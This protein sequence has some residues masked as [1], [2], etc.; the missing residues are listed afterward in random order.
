VDNFK[1]VEAVTDEQKDQG[2][3]HNHYAF[4]PSPNLETLEKRKK[5]RKFSIENYE[6]HVLVDN[7]PVST[8]IIVPMKQ[9]IRGK[10]FPMGGVAGV[11]TYPEARRKGYVKHLIKHLMEYMYDNNFVVSTLYPFRESFYGKFGWI[12]FN[13]VKVAI[14]SPANLHPLLKMNFE[15]SVS[16]SMLKEQLHHY[17][18]IIK[19]VVETQHGFCSFSDLNMDR[20]GESELWATVAKDKNDKAIGFM[21]YKISGFEGTFDVSKFLYTTS[22]GKYLL[23][24]FLARH[25]DQ[26]KSINM[27]LYAHENIENWIFDLRPEI[28]S[29]EWVPTAMGRIINLSLLSGIYVRPGKLFVNVVDEQLPKNN[30][31]WEF[32]E[33]NGMLK[34]Q[35]VGEAK[36][37]ISIQALS[38]IVYGTYTIE[39]IQ[40]QSEVE[41]HD[42]QIQTL[43]D[44]FSTQKVSLNENF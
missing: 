40:F 2:D 28:R 11:T 31:S 10:I 24:E 38:A 32:S 37:K 39:D 42:D 12:N 13:Q 14:F 21:S 18:Q 26:V 44:M 7:N 30:G 8:A 20:L 23:L 15:G 36:G 35:K 34:L 33:E 25:I 22:E 6:A 5:L 41:L 4:F 1:I 29:R 16:R 27:P 3:L 9:N 43:K 17:K 19:E